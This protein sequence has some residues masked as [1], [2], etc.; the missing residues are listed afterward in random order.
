MVQRT[1]VKFALFGAGSR[2]EL[3][4]GYFFEKNPKEIQYWAVAE[5]DP[6]RRAYFVERFKIPK[7]NIFNDWR[8]LLEKPKLADAIINALPCRMHHESTIAALKA[9]YDVLLEKPIAHT[10]GECIHLYNASKKYKQKLSVCFENRYNKIYQETKHL[11]DRGIIGQIMDITCDESIAYWH[12]AHSYVRGIHSR[13]DEG[14]SFMIAKGIHDTDLLT[15]FIQSKAKK[16]SSFGDLL[17]FNKINAPPGAP[18][19][20]IEGCPVQDK[21]IFDAMKQYYKPGHMKLPVKLLLS[22]SFKDLKDVIQYKRFRTLASTLTRDLNKSTILKVLSEEPHGKCVFHSNNI[23]IC[24]HQSS[25]IEFE[26]DVTATFSLSAFSLAWERSL[27]FKGIKGEI[28]TKDF[29]GIL[30]IR[31]YNPAKIKKKR[32]RYRGLHHG[33]G[34]EYL[35]LD[36]AKAVKNDDPNVKSLTSIETCIESHLIALAAEEARLSGKVVDMAIFRR[37]AEEKAIMLSNKKEK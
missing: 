12:Y 13:A 22:Q 17:F 26:N 24:D 23:G 4:L 33:G 19:R 8:D 3:D 27:D 10:P 5:P 21:C 2:G 30:E 14:N 32:I 18:D 7:E 25:I 16:I 31:T 9:G 1:P 36:F 11:L 15:W 37:K 35:L 28:N 34:D 29:S 20:C 6:I